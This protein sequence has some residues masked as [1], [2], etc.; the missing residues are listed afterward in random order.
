MNKITSIGSADI[1]L[2][3]SEDVLTGT[4]FKIASNCSIE[5]FADEILVCQKRKNLYEVKRVVDRLKNTLEVTV[6]HGKSLE[7]SKM[8]WID[9]IKII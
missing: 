3:L 5:S 8:S 6:T 7:I 9:F 4:N 2:G 1:T